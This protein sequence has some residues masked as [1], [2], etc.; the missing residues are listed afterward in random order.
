MFFLG[1]GYALKQVTGKWPGELY[2]EYIAEKKA[3][4]ER[5]L[6]R[7]DHDPTSFNFIGSA[8]DGVRQS[9]PIWISDNEILYQFSAIQCGHRILYVQHRD[10]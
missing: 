10:Q 2:N 8:Y 7:V 3:Q 6:D 1:Y 9:A 4:E 5:R